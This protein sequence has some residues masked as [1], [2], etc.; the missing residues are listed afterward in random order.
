MPGMSDLIP[1]HRKMKP[2]N[3]WLVGLGSGLLIYFKLTGIYAE[4]PL[5][6]PPFL[7]AAGFIVCGI[8]VPQFRK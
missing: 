8:I 1:L 2:P 7:I 5:Y 3:L 6:F 4:L